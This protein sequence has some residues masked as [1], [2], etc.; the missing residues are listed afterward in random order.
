VGQK[1]V[2]KKPKKSR[3]QVFNKKQLKKRPPDV[4]ANIAITP[5]KVK[6]K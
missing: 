5:K 2:A 4:T 6:N 3:H 1:T